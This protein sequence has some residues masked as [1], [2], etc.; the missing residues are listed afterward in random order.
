[1][2]PQDSLAEGMFNPVSHT[3]PTLQS[4]KPSPSHNLFVTILKAAFMTSHN[5][6]TKKE[7]F[8]YAIS[9]KSD[10][11]FMNFLLPYVHVQTEL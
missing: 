3:Y 5:F 1:M 6:Y 2:A 4:W 9:D 8:C 11:E 10:E 7:D